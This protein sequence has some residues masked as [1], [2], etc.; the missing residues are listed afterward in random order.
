MEILMARTAVVENFSPY[1]QINPDILNQKKE[2]F[3][4][5]F[6][7]EIEGVKGDAQF[8]AVMRYSDRYFDYGNQFL[9]KM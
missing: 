1:Y 7:K 8:S 4:I 6:E 2:A 5:A 9:E 3:K